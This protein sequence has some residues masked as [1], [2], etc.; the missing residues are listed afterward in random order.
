MPVVDLNYLSLQ[1]LLGSKISK[2]TILENLPFLG[3]DIESEENDSVRVEYSPNRPDYST[4]IGISLGL[5]GILGIKR[6]ATKLKISKK[7]EYH[8]RADPSV[9]SIRPFVTGIIAKN[10]N[11]DT[12]FIRKLMAMQEDLHFGIGRKRV[13][14]SIGIHDLDKVKFPLSYCTTNHSHKFVPLNSSEEQTVTQILQNSD[15]GKTYGHIISNSKR[16]PIILDENNNT[17]SL[18]PIIN[19]NLT[20]VTTN[21]KNLFV[22]VTGIN[23]KDIEDML[24][25][26]AII[27]QKAGF[28][29]QTVKIT[30][31]NNSTPT[32]K[33]RKIV[34]N[35]SLPGNSLGIDIKPTEII[36]SLQRSRIDA[37]IKGKTIHC[38][39]PPYRFDILGEM[40]LVEEI[41][42]GYGI[43]KFTPIL[44]PS[45]TFG[46]EN[47]ISEKLKLVSATMIGLGFSEVVNSSLTSTRILFELTKRDPKKIISVLDSKSQEHTIL[48]D[49]LLPGLIDVLSKNIHEQYPQRLF[50][51]GTVFSYDDPIKEEIH[52]SA[53]AALKNTN[54]SE[55]KSVLQSL[56]RFGMNLDLKTETSSY[57]TMQEGR[58]ANVITNEK[59]VGIV[60]EIDSQIIENLKIRVPVV[61]FEIKLSG[62][63]F[64]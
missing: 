16:V 40:D 60:G 45:Q 20:T 64:D 33:D 42:L 32:F 14:S 30:G 10:G 51:I 9:S 39:I 27:L 3:L 26:V 24:S 13:K 23:K 50:E 6:G 25:V 54:Y 61:A 17:I 29:L 62:L 34:I 41:A 44:S 4:D 56:L 8:I 18:P 63:I 55:I 31:A 46:H 43:Q 47:I 11:V 57:P 22:E 1:K 53:I 2:K 12:D 52:I 28:D 21:T 5:E 37:F 35:K 19:S 59:N 58:T 36:S 48:R 15:V 49:S 7:T 38:I